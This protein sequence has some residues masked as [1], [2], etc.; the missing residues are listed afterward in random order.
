MLGVYLLIGVEV[1]RCAPWCRARVQ[2][3]AWDTVAFHRELDRSPALRW[4]LKRNL[5]IALL[6]VKP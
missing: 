5:S 3:C 6:S 4:M 2:R 1:G